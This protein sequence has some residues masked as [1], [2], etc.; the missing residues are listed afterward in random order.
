M[1]KIHN[2]SRIDFRVPTALGF[3]LLVAAAVTTLINKVKIANELGIFAY[4]TLL[5]GVLAQLLGLHFSLPKVLRREII[6]IWLLLVL[7]LRI[8]I[9]S[10]WLN[11]EVMNKTLLFVFFCWR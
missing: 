2:F 6:L 10:G 1:K 7:W 11:P 4:F 8:F 3:F 9:N 5:V